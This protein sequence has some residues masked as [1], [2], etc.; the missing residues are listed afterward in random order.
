M[1][2]TTPAATH[3]P[4]PAAPPAPPTGT[5]VPV[6]D[7]PDL[8]RTVLVRPW[9][10][11]VIDEHGHDPRSAYVERFWLPILGPSTTWLLRRL[12]DGLDQ[13]PEGYQLDLADLAGELGLALRSTRTSP[14]LRAVDRSCTFGAARQLGTGTLAVRRH[15]APLSRRQVQRLPDHLRAEHEAGDGT[16]PSS[17][18]S[19][20]EIRQ[21]ARTLALSLLQLGESE[22]DTERQLHRWHVHPAMAHDALRWARERHPS[23]A[24][25]T[26]S[27]ALDAV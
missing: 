19:A 11:P 5:G 9:D 7:D 25:P 20:D 24:R 3:Q 10:D 17:P 1:P 8:D 21:R 16:A 13:R 18:P 27:T 2:T 6:D 15:L 12:A 23:S 4:R 14:L 22:R 26:E